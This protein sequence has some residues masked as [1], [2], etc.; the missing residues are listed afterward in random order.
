[1]SI[2]TTY[3]CQGEG[4]LP[5]DYYTK[6]GSPDNVTLH[7]WGHYG[8]QS[9]LAGQSMKQ[10]LGFYNS[11]EDLNADLLDAG[12]APEWVEWSSKFSEPQNSFNHLPDES[13]W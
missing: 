3:N 10:F 9:V 6:T 1:M 5:F 7:G 2:S 11:E 8:Y 4:T 12:I 13:D